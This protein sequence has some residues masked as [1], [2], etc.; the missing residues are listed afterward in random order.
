MKTNLP[1]M[2]ATDDDGDARNDK[3]IR[4]ALLDGV[5]PEAIVAAPVAANEGKA[6]VATLLCVA[7]PFLAVPL[8][9]LEGPDAAIA[10]L[11]ILSFLGL[12]TANVI[13]PFQ[14]TEASDDERARRGVAI[15]RV[16]G[17]MADDARRIA[18]IADG[19]IQFAA[20]GN[21]T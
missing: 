20:A 5:A 15:R 7:G 18:E 13:S 6:L 3:A 19:K 8:T 12:L 9:T 17:A 1:S 21:P 2:R 14:S 4:T 11:V 16:A 10:G